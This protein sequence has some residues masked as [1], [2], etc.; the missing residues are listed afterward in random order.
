MRR[1]KIVCTLGP[2]TDTYD[3][4]KALVQAGMDVARLNLS[5]G[6]YADHEERYRHV[7]KAGEETGRGVGV[8]ADLQGPKIRLGVF[9]DGPVML[10]RGDEFTLTVDHVAGDRHLCGTTY[11]GLAKDV[12]TGDRILVDD[13]K[14]ALEVTSVEGPRVHTLVIEGGMVSDHKGINL[15]GVAVSVPTLSAKDADDLRWALRTGADLIALS[16]VRS[17]RDIAEVHRIMDEEGHRLPVIAKIEK[18]QAVEDIAGIV[19]A[20]DGIM[21][22]RGDLGVEMPLEQVPLV[23]KRAITLA[24]RNAKP[25]IVATQMLESMIEHSRPTRA[26]A[27]DVANAVI[28]G[29]DAVMLSGETSVGAYPVET[30]RTMARIVEAAE[31]DLLS[32]GLADIP[33]HTKPRTQGGAVARAA[34]ELGDF[35]GAKFLIAFTESGDTVK[36]LSRYR[37]PIPLLAFTPVPATQAQ[38]N[39]TWGV[40]AY[41]A[42]EVDTTDEMVA[43]VDEHLLRVG[44]CQKGDLVVITAGS[45]PGMPG[46]TNLVRVHHV[47]EDD[48]PK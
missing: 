6:T 7:R 33:A 2:A 12:D 11:D 15:P 40:E 22:A 28:D 37:S 32:R 38:L 3:Q 1:A 4:V 19:A 18:P 5:H 30:V 35:L 29:T 41:L 8:L 25:V 48:S 43:Q 46:A 34:A 36:R 26:E 13:G 10:E 14:V 9:P 24:K 31:E 47:G 39:L 20:F 44:R 21:V 42:P 16:F 23:Q 45:P 17:G 27:S